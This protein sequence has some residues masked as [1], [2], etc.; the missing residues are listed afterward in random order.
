M[1]G[2]LFI[3]I[4]HNDYLPLVLE[5]IYNDPNNI[6]FSKAKSQK[7]EEI[8]RLKINK[9]TYF[10]DL[11]GNLIRENGELAAE[12]ATKILEPLLQEFR[13]MKR[14]ELNDESEDQRLASLINLISVVFNI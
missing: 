10:F 14:I 4:M 1:P 2:D 13:S 11:F 12:T 5:K 9:C 6:D 3:D 8:E 7:Y